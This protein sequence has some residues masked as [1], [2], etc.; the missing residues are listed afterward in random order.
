MVPV[1]LPEANAILLQV[2]QLTSLSNAPMVLANGVQPY[3]HQ[4]LSVLNGSHISVVMENV[5]VIPLIVE[6]LRDVQLINPIDV[7]I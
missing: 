2:V 4:A 7:L 3:V 1:L 6:L 5:K